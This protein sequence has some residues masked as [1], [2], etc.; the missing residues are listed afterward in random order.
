[1]VSFEFLAIILTGIGLIASIL[2]YTFTLQNANKTR[3]AQLFSQIYQARYNQDYIQR[4]WEIMSWDWKDFDDYYSK[5]GGFDVDPEIAAVSI[6]QFSYY[7][8]LGLLVKN[9]M[10]DVETVFQLMSAPII[11]LWFKCETVIK[12]MRVMENG[13][14]M[15][16]MDS[17]EFLANEMIRMRLEKGISLPTFVL[18][19]T[20][21]LHSVYHQ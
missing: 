4:W 11:S 18:H 17:F 3:Q 2:Y 19:P 21:T 16:Y 20:S 15:N 13:P 8:G 1:M 10:V 6:A 9:R 5:Y 14:G 7:D 12:G